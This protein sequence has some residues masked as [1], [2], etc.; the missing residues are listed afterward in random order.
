MTSLAAMAGALMVRI[1][2]DNLASLLAG[3][4]F[5]IV[6]GLVSSRLLGITV[7][8]W[9]SMATALV[10]TLIGVAGAQAVVH[11]GKDGVVAWALTACSGSWPPWC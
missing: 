9:R 4:V 10:G 3:V 6:L 7:G 11:G 1:T 5:V 2:F 8:R